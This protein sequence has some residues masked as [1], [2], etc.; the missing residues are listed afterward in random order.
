LVERFVRIEEVRGS[1]P[2]SSTVTPRSSDRSAHCGKSLTAYGGHGSE[3]RRTARQGGW[4]APTAAVWFFHTPRRCRHRASRTGGGR[5]Q[6][7]RAGG[8][9]GHRPG[10]IA[11]LG[12][13]P[14][15]GA[16]GTALPPCRLRRLTTARLNVRMTL[17]NRGIW[18][19]DGRAWTLHGLPAGCSRT[20]R[21]SLLSCQGYGRASV[22]S[23]DCRS[24]IQG[25]ARR[26]SRS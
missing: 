24:R 14:E 3:R 4:N 10:S 20:A 15:W 8:G 1:N 22:R 18:A 11:V 19:G 17:R 26:P 13:A 7:R 25:A 5:G 2:L 23:R 12:H 21:P 9:V 16:A 6:H